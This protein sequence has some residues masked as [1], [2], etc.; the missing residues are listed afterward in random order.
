MFK[1]RV[2][3]KYYRKA[4]DQTDKCYWSFL[5]LLLAVT[6]LFCDSANKIN[7]IIIIIIMIITT[8]LSLHRLVSYG[9]S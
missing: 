4:L 2:L 7:V 9:R 5:N 1:L 3:V 6:A 8:L